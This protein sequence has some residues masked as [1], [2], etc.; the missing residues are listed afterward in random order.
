MY[1]ELDQ[2]KSKIY[3][4]MPYKKIEFCGEDECFQ[5][6]IAWFNTAAC[7]LSDTDMTVLL[8]N[9]NIYV[10]IEGNPALIKEINEG[11]YRFEYLADEGLLPVD[12]MEYLPDVAG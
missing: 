2:L 11:A 9:E 6:A 1:N 10:R 7:M 5:T 12:S 4:K 8:E 3:E